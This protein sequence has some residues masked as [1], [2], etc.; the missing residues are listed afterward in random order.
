MYQRDKLHPS[1]V[2]WSLGNE[3]GGTH[4]TDK[5]YEYL[6]THTDKQHQ[7]GTWKVG[8][9]KKRTQNHD[10]GAPAIGIVHEC[11]SGNAIQPLL[12]AVDNI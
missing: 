8:Q 1:I 3:A 2:M 12:Q 4:N 9:L 10:R 11:L 6:G 7:V 5:E